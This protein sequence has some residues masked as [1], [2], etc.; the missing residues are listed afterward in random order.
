ME[1]HADLVEEQHAE[2]DR[3]LTRTDDSNK[4]TDLKKAVTDDDSAENKLLDDLISAGC[5]LEATARRIMMNQLP[6]GSAPQT[7]LRADRNQQLRDMRSLGVDEGEMNE[8]MS[9]EGDGNSDLMQQVR[10]FPF[11]EAVL[12]ETILRLDH[13]VP[14]DVRRIP[15]YRFKATGHARALTKSFRAATRARGRQG[16]E[17]TRERGFERV[18]RWSGEGEGDGR[19]ER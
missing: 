19:T 13:Q 5:S 15:G 10:L 11:P 8:I 1:T 7:L 18:R 2:I 4:G 9:E 6:E 16:R 12:T 14:E 17:G 3:E